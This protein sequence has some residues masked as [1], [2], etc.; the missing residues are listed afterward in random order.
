MYDILA[1]PANPSERWDV[2]KSYFSVFMSKDTEGW[3]WW[4]GC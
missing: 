4:R 3:S 1:C 2:G